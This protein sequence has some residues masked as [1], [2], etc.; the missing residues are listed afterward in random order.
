M[1]RNT[2]IIMFGNNRDAKLFELV[3]LVQLVRHRYFLSSQC[4]TSLNGS[5]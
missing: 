1:R 3:Y 2:S 5:G 4:P